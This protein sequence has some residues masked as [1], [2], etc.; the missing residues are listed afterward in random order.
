MTDKTASAPASH[1]QR[2][3]SSAYSVSFE[4]VPAITGTLPFATL[5]AKAIA[6]LVADDELSSDYIIPAPFDERVGK[7]VASAV[8]TAAK[9]SG[10]AR[11]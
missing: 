11:V 2:V 1:A 6:S 10:V 3:R 4:P 9:E 7:A 5:A 8:A